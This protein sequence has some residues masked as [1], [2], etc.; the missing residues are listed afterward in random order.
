MR[1]LESVWRCLMGIPRNALWEQCKHGYTHRCQ[2]CFCIFAKEANQWRWICWGRIFAARKRRIEVYEKQRRRRRNTIRAF[3]IMF[4]SR[5]FQRYQGEVFVITSLLHVYKHANSI[6]LC[7]FLSN[8]NHPFDL[9]SACLQIN[10]T[11]YFSWEH[12]L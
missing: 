5:D 4:G 1:I 6:H 2:A 10:L 9:K 7:D 8:E 12:D 3:T 11:T